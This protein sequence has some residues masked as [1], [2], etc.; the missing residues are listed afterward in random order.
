MNLKLVVADGGNEPER[1]GSHVG[2]HLELI[3]SELANAR[4][5]CV[6][7][8]F[9][10]DGVVLLHMLLQQRPDIPVLFVD[11]FHHFDAH[12][13]TWLAHYLREAGRPVIAESAER[14]AE[15]H[16]RIAADLMR[17]RDL[18]TSEVAERVGYSSEDALAKVFRRYV[19]V[20]PTE[21]RRRSE[22][23]LA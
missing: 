5:P 2:D 18:S 22:A 10:A 16:R 11:T 6:T 23:G 17:R 13:F 8:S 3:A 1:R 20:T 12:R 4:R 21:W 15:E 9:Q 7:T 14:W 19:G